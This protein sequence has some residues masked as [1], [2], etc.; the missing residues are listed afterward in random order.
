M[1]AMKSDSIESKESQ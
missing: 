1:I